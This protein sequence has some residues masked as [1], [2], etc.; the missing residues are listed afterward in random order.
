MKIEHAKE[1][2]KAQGSSIVPGLTFCLARSIAL[3]EADGALSGSPNP[4]TP[5]EDC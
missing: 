4:F 1:M 3:T 2:K 5:S